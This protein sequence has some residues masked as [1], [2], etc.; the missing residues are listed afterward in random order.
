MAERKCRVQMLDG[1]YR[2]LNIQHNL[3]GSELFDLIASQYSLQEKQYFGL[4]YTDPE[5]G[6]NIWLD[7]KSKVLDQVP[8]AKSTLQ[9]TFAIKVYTDAITQVKNLTT[10]KLFF[11][12]V[13]RLISTGNL[14]CE[15][16]VAFTLAAIALQAIEGDFISESATRHHLDAKK[17]IPD[18][19]LVAQ[20]SSLETCAS[21]VSAE[22]KTLKGMDDS[23][24]VLTFMTIAQTLPQYG[25]HFFD[26]KD[27]SGVPWR[28]GVSPRGISQF[29]FSNP[30]SPRQV[31]TW[32]AVHNVTNSKS[33]FVIE[34]LP[35]QAA[36]PAPL[37]SRSTSLSLSGGST[38]SQHSGRRI[39]LLKRRDDS[40]RPLRITIVWQT[41]NTQYAKTMVAT[42]RE[43]KRHFN[44]SSPTPRKGRR[45]SAAHGMAQKIEALAL[46]DN[47][48]MAPSAK[49]V[50]VPAAATRVRK[51]LSLS[52][53][54]TST[55]GL[56][57]SVADDTT[58]EGRDEAHLEKLLRRRR[59]IELEIARKEKF[60]ERL[61]KDER[62]YLLTLSGDALHN[63]MFLEDDEDEDD[64]DDED[65]D[66]EGEEE[67]AGVIELRE[68]SQHDTNETIGAVST[69]ATAT[70]ANDGGGVDVLLRGA[71]LRVAGRRRDS[72]IALDS[73]GDDDDDDD[74]DGGEYVFDDEDEDEEE[75]KDNND[76][77]DDDAGNIQD[78]RHGSSRGDDVTQ[79]AASPSSST[80]TT[81]SYPS[82]QQHEA[83]AHQH[84]PPKNSIKPSSSLPLSPSRE[85]ARRS[86]A[87][88]S[89][90]F[91]PAHV[92]PLAHIPRHRTAGSI[93][94]ATSATSVP[95]SRA[96]VAGDADSGDGGGD[97]RGGGDG[98]GDDVLASMSSSSSHSLRRRTSNSSR[99]SS[100]RRGNSVRGSSRPG[101]WRVPVSVDG[102]PDEVVFPLQSMDGDDGDGT[103][104][105]FV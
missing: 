36:S 86:N 91:L 29:Y 20:G 39:T 57:V 103:R 12:Q 48:L 95:S 26:V 69:A 102:D 43:Q 68:E 1:S 60:L 61:E 4:Y 46:S 66:E 78:G 22:Y 100:G 71:N 11:Q 77:N 31:Y 32:D 23:S 70:A 3:H 10:Q 80:T 30:N 92:A 18:E 5:S 93:A 56:V 7:L 84:A 81:T 38:G 21:K 45:T 97:G 24:A 27:K 74:E 82:T 9:L 90:D 65:D 63:S 15:S 42:C 17:L 79:V 94:S 44:V 88:S 49:E 50:K 16:D 72:D 28:L 96:S 104:I 33:K 6:L 101:P 83:I 89:I 73:S 13:L 41:H 25:M 2:T 67:G 14:S 19:V 59:Q 64:E 53:S 99:R 34:L 98:G 62:E 105:T 55:S 87:S 8:K 51:L 35:S 47:K 58:H 75:V 76:G 40:S 54:Q 37:P 85:R 52:E